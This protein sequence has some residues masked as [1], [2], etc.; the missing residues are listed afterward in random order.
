MFPIWCHRVLSLLSRAFPSLSK[1]RDQASWTFS[2]VLVFWLT[3][4]RFPHLETESYFLPLWGLAN[5]FVKSELTLG[6][7]SGE[8]DGDDREQKISSSVFTFWEKIIKKNIK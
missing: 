1:T 5:D 3:F 8:L 7:A 2:R 6:N 4:L